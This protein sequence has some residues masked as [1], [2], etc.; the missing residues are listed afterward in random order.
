MALA[1]STTVRA[2][3]PPAPSPPAAAAPATTDPPP[4]PIQEVVVKGERAPVETT[5]DRTIYSVRNDLQAASGSAADVL[6][7]VPSITVDLDGNPSLRGDASVTILV[8]G[9]LA[10]EFNGSNRGAALQ[11]LGA[12]NIDRIEVLTNPPVQFK[13]DG[14]GGIINIITKRKPGTRSASVQASLGSSGR[15]NFGTS[16]GVQI[17]KVQL[18]GSASLRHEGRKREFQDDRVVR[19]DTG[20]VLD[21]RRVHTLGD[22][23]RMSKNLSLGADLDITPEDR[24]TV[25]G[26]FFRFDSDSTVRDHG[27]TFD[28]TGA[29]TSEYNRSRLGDYSDYSGSAQLRYHHKGENDG[30]GLTV[31]AE[32][33][34]SV[35]N[36]ALHFPKSFVTP[37]QPGTEQRHR[38]RQEQVTDELSVDWV[39]TTDDRKFSAGYDLTRNDYLYDNAQTFIVPVGAAMPLDPNYTN[40]FRY[41]QTVHALYASYELPY[42]KWTWLAGMRLEDTA[43]DLNQVTTD[44]Q[45]SQ[46][47]FRV[48][49]S[50]HVSRGIGE[51]QKLRFSATRRVFRPGGSDL[52]PFP[53]Q[54]GEFAVRAGNPDLEPSDYD[55]FEAGWSYEAGRTT[56]SA[57]AFMRHSS[58]ART[59]ITT[60]FSPTVTLVTPANLAEQTSGGVEFAASG[61]ITPKLD[62]NISG[63]VFYTEIDAANLGFMDTRST[64][65]ADAKLALNWRATEKGTFQVNAAVIGRRVTPQGERPS[66]ATMDL[67]FRHQFKPNLSVTATVTDVFNTRRFVNVLDTSELYQAMTFRPQGQVVFVGVTWSLAAG[68]KQQE[69]FEYEQGG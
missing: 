33:S 45:G 37:V 62:Y 13:R 11:Q 30:D 53:V 49:P 32:R 43:L 14:S 2:A 24:L 46:T 65:A 16:Q 56:R 34:E 29:S 27:L 22:D 47:Y 36:G 54:S 5:I 44:Q 41:A 48:Y 51:H 1:A 57:T 3:D 68:K 18:R 67:G 39:K 8:D 10:P 58:N 59:Q 6:R 12:A 28:A 31:N 64:Y 23:D 55:S 42:G 25:G 4:A 63:T 60:L 52:N 21:D 9:R 61:R 50:L 20:V 19:D 26:T 69:K 7:N 66:N 17:G 15:Y 40:V 35:Q 38:Y